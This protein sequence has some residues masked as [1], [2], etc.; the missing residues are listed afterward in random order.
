MNISFCLQWASTIAHVQRK[1]V[2]CSLWAVLYAHF[3][4]MYRERK[5]IAHYEQFFML[6]LMSKSQSSEN[7]WIWET[8]SF[9]ETVESVCGSFPFFS[10]SLKHKPIMLSFDHARGRLVLSFLIRWSA[11]RSMPISLPISLPISWTLLCL[12]SLIKFMKFQHYDGKNIWTL[13]KNL[14]KIWEF[15]WKFR[16]CSRYKFQNFCFSHFFSLER[17]KF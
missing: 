8:E 2:H 17:E 6:I 10:F 7:Y 1:K 12:E 15:F 5:Y 14:K 11:S 13:S 16:K 4:L 9:S 3:E